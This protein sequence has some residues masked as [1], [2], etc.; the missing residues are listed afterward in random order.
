MSEYLLLWLKIIETMSNDNTYKLAWGK[1]LIEITAE[2]MTDASELIIS[3]RAIGYKML[4]YYWNQ[5]FFFKLKQSS[6]KKPVVVQETE[7]CIEKYI[8]I[9]QSNL[10]KWFDYADEKLRRE[11]DFYN[12]ALEKIARA[13]KPDVSWRFL[14]SGEEEL[15]LYKLDRSNM[16]VTFTRAQVDD[17]KQCSLVFAQLLNYKWAELLEKFNSSPRIVSKVRGLSEA[18]LRQSSLT[19]FKSIYYNKDGKESG[20]AS[21][22]SFPSRA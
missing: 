9:S 11:P 6:G 19:K 16:T 15:P 17:I 2:D 12:N 14:K 21:P 13:L 1:A 22:A 8:E 3:F 4:K 20:T 10:P 7:S 5:I 18:K